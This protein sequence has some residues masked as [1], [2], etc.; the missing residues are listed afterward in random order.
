MA[1]T[2]HLL[3]ARRRAQTAKA[4]TAYPPLIVRSYAG[5]ASWRDKFRALPCTGAEAEAAFGSM[6]SKVFLRR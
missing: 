3:L 2:T 1:G 5:G 6:L 4:T